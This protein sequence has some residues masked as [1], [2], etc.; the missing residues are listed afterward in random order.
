[1]TSMN[2]LLDS[3][4]VKQ[5]SETINPKNAKRH[6]KTWLSMLKNGDLD[7]EESN[8]PKFQDIILNKILGYDTNDIK[9]EKDNIEYQIMDQDKKTLI[10]IEA[11]GASTK[12]LWKKTSTEKRGA[13]G[14]LWGY[15]VDLTPKYGICTNYDKFILF[16]YEAGRC[17]HYEFEFSSIAENEY[18]LKEFI[19]VFSKE[20]LLKNNSFD[21]TKKLGVKIERDIE[22][23]FYDI[24][25]NT[26]QM[27]VKEFEEQV[28]RD[29]AID[30][31]QTF[32]NR[33]IF[34]MFSASRGYVERHILI[35]QIRKQTKI[36]KIT[37]KTSIVYNTINMIFEWF[38]HG[39]KKPDV[40]AF[41]GGLFADRWGT[42]AKFLDLRPSTGYFDSLNEK[43]L[44]FIEGPVDI[45]GKQVDINNI[46][47][48][49]KNITKLVSYDFESDLTVNILGHIF[50]QSLDDIE[51]MNNNIVDERKK[52]GVYYTPSYITD[53][54]CRQTIIPYLCKDELVTDVQKL[55]KQYTDLD[56][57]N[58]LE[59]KLKKITILDPACG[60][61]AFLV[62]AVE[63]LFEIHN[64]IHESKNESGQYD[65]EVKGKKSESL[66]M[67]SID[68]LTD[69]DL[70]RYIVENCI[71]GID[72]NE[73][74]V[75]I[76][77]IAM[78]FKLA[79][80]QK[81]LP[82]LS[83]NI[84]QG[85][86]ILSK[87]TKTEKRFD[88]AGPTGFP[89]ICSNKDNVVG[90]MPGFDIIIGNPPYVRQEKLKDDKDYMQL[91]KSNS[92]RGENLKIDKKSDKSSYFYY[93]C[94]NWLK[95]GGRLGFIV[96]DS[97]LS[98]GYGKSLRKMILENCSINILL[99]PTYNVFKNIDVKTIITILTKSIST[100]NIVRYQLLDEGKLL[101]HLN[102]KEKPQLEFTRDKW[103]VYFMTDVYTP[104][105]EMIPLNELGEL[106]RG[107]STNFNN[108]FVINDERR[109]QFDINEKY[110][111]P[112]VP[113]HPP[114][115]KL[116]NSD[117][118]VFLL[119]VN[120][121]KSELQRHDDAK[122]LME[123]IKS[124]EKDEYR[125]KNSMMIPAQAPTLKKKGKGKKSKIDWY[126]IKDQNF[127]DAF[128]SEIIHERHIILQN[129]LDL[130]RPFTSLDTWVCFKINK[131]NDLPALLAY[132]RSS[133][134]SLE[135]E[136]IGHTM[137]AGA[138]KM[139]VADYKSALVPK[140]SKLDKK[141]KDE[142]SAAWYRYCKNLNQD[143]LDTVVFNVLDGS[144]EQERVT[145]YVNKSIQKRLSVK[146]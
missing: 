113:K 15:M 31:A 93:H 92:L 30:Q 104:N 139:Q 24:F 137:G 4:A 82:D 64:E 45:F 99:K 133:I 20:T 39:H 36:K 130:N 75:E 141:K 65:V 43:N 46:S 80:D 100:D 37:D 7:E 140:I 85:N 14:Q 35:E 138:L 142:L 63:V 77:K 5:L 51:K 21:Q 121:S 87:K 71:F 13:I 68:E 25:F 123:Y 6:A 81:R 28:S 47:P 40:F 102:Y 131:P 103:S 144:T 11:K 61:G 143:T 52:M 122:G 55:V 3:K 101:S 112:L 74:S 41:N 33:L 8:Y 127:P 2:S 23:E 48:L 128:F 9:F 97:W 105:I 106:Y 70:I 107:T 60:S 50:E 53:Y 38:S 145:N 57:L 91:P 120:E 108:Y 27:L 126:Y 58:S 110:L 19:W 117:I 84:K 88:W 116:Q 79:G 124:G 44:K 125:H 69:R 129:N 136:R 135:L 17:K 109:K 118:S 115:G 134:F 54:V 72:I 114:L 34:V 94:I 18:K 42:N 90:I 86:T 132:L 83:D 76:S 59:E 10:C 111:I 119:V 146:K 66:T 98:F 78:F 16:K 89:N 96:S 26:R 29:I 56:D 95:S 22:D 32:L 73:H 67:K 12:D 49:I 1:M 62:K